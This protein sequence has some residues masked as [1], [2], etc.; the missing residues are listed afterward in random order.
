MTARTALHEMKAFSDTINKNVLAKPTEWTESEIQQL[1]AW[2]QYIAWETGNPLQL[3]DSG[4]VMERVVY[5]YQQALIYQRFYPEI[6]YEFSNYYIE[7][8]KP[9]RALATLA[10]GIEVLPSRFVKSSFV[11]VSNFYRFLTNT[12][13]IA[14][15]YFTLHMYNFAKAKRRYQRHAKLWTTCW[16]T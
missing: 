5:A 13:A 7:V 3:E 9:D 11:S 4:H 1:D 15:C 14:V 2:K 12:C 16:S 8:D 10:M 6:W